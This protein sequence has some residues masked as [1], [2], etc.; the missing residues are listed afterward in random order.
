MK[1]SN[2]NWNDVIKKET[3]G[4]DGANLGEVQGLEQVLIVT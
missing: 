1:E 2:I 4:L 3:R